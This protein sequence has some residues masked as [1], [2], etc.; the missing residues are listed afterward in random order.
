MPERGA[1]PSV[2]GGAVPLPDV[3]RLRSACRSRSLRSPFAVAAPR[4]RRMNRR[5]LLRRML[6]LPSAGTAMQ[7]DPAR[8]GHV[9]LRAAAMRNVEELGAG[10]F[11]PSGLDSFEVGRQRPPGDD[12]CLDAAM[13]DRLP[14]PRPPGRIP[15]PASD[16]DLG[17]E[18]VAVEEGVVPG[19]GTAMRGVAACPEPSGEF[20]APVG[21][22]ARVPAVAD[23]ATLHAPMRRAPRWPPPSSAPRTTRRL[24]RATPIW[25]S[26][27]PS[28]V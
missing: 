2:R 25:S 27:R 14:P 19:T 12:P 28:I 8:G 23:D 17:Q 13:F 15:S 9:R 26:F 7:V 4:R 20:C 16:T 24:P 6:A 10:T 11:E 5:G 22:I 3:R 21:E 1:V 18:I